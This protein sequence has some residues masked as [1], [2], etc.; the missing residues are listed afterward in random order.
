MPDLRT[1][2]QVTLTVKQ[3]TGDI[4]RMHEAGWYIT[5]PTNLYV[6]ENGEAVMGRGLAQ[7]ATQKFQRCALW[8]GY[9]LKDHVRQVPDGRNPR[10]EDIN[11][12]GL[13]AVHHD[14]RAVFL[15]VKTSWNQQARKGL[16][17]K[18]LVCLARTIQRPDTTMSEVGVA[19]PRIGCGNGLLDWESDVKPMVRE[20]LTSLSDE[21]RAR[22]CIVHPPPDLPPEPPPNWS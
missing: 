14:W 12:K 11:E 4:W 7:Q 2:L 17:E 6:K 1:G 9:E 5:I 15:P 10:M 19:L 21:A 13:I 8:Y 22:V 16:I 3:Y 20:F 18:S